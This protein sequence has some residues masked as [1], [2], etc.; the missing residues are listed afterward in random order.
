MNPNY[1][2]SH[3]FPFYCFLLLAFSWGLP[4]P[5]FAS[6]RSASLKHQ[7]GHRST[8]RWWMSQGPTRPSLFSKG[9]EAKPDRFF[10]ALGDFGG[11]PTGPNLISKETYV[12]SVA[13]LRS[14]SAIFRYSG[15]LSV[16]AWRKKAVACFRFKFSKFLQI[17]DS[18]GRFYPA[19]FPHMKIRDI[20]ELREPKLQVVSEAGNQCSDFVESDI[21]YP[22]ISQWCNSVWQWYWNDESPLWGPYND[23]DW[24]G[25]LSM[26]N[27]PVL[28][29]TCWVMLRPSYH[30][31]SQFLGCT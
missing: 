12:E 4:S 29:L 26:S 7:T 10:E 2:F 5:S 19:L 6:L 3:L 23:C 11:H 18:L 14:N 9:A 24:D 22:W 30:L 25:F 21:G 8:P 31:L 13:I 1:R 17:S 15:E 28:P 27:I 20:V 16:V